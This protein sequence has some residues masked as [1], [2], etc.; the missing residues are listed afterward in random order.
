ME[1]LTR[2]Y[3]R[4][5][6]LRGISLRTDPGEV[7]GIEGSNGS[8][9]TTLLRVAA[10]LVRP[11]SGNVRVCGFD[12]LHDAAE[13]R[14]HVAMLTHA[15]GLYSDLTARENLRFAAA[16]MGV[17][18]GDIPRILER[19]GL[20]RHADLRVGRFSSGMQRRVALGRLMMKTPRLLLLDEPYNSFDPPGV[21]LVNDVIRA[22]SAQG[23]ATLIVLHDRGPAAGV[24]GRW[25]RLREGKI[26]DEVA[27]SASTTRASSALAEVAVS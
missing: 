18:E 27:P 15:T 11:T 9:K 21:E 5:W 22:V 1:A 10:T 3:G 12:V 25:I 26:S 19:L 6:A 16:M 4:A 24:V 17:G 13:A 23:G 20:A 2:R 7:L 14:P 8:G